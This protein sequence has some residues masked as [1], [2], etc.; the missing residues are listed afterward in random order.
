MRQLKIWNGRP[1]GK[2]SRQDGQYHIYVAAYG[3]KQAAELVGQACE[4]NVSVH[5]IQEYYSKNC[6]GNS[7]DGIVATEPCVYV[8][9]ESQF[10][11]RDPVTGRPLSGIWKHPVKRVS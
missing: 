1:H 3:A 11:D 10:I 4:A 2:Y 6:W 9:D 8:S 7:M 5:E